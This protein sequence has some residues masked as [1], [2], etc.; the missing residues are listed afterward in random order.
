MSALV[1]SNGGG[2]GFVCGGE[3][4]WNKVRESDCRCVREARSIEDIEELGSGGAMRCVTAVREACE[5]DV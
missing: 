3:R 4:D 1:P 5:A 2:G